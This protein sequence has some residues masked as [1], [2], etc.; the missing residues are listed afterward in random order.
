MD[1][2]VDQ[3]ENAGVVYKNTRNRWFSPPLIVRK[4]EANEF[5]MTVDVRAVNAQTERMVWPMP[6]LEVVFDHLVG[7]SMFFSLDFSKDIGSSSCQEIVSFLT[8]QGVYRPTRVL[9]ASSESVA[10]AGPRCK[11]CLRTLCNMAYSFDWITCLVTLITRRLFWT[12]WP[13]LGICQEIGLKLNPKKGSFYQTEAHWRGRSRYRDKKWGKTRNNLCV[14][15]D[16]LVHTGL[17]C[18]SPPTDGAPG[19]GVQSG[20]GQGQG[21]QSDVGRRGMDEGA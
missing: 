9:M 15:L 2:H 16:A 8:D 11:E 19:T 14:E 5:R 6:L 7:A 17:Q 12:C 18:S 10:T 20:R 13:V 4:P 21:G 1:S 3:L